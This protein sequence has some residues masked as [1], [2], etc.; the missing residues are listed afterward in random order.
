[1]Q[2]MIGVES[3]GLKKKVVTVWCEYAFAYMQ[4][5]GMDLG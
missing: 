4:L 5:K 3:F 1:M 2:D